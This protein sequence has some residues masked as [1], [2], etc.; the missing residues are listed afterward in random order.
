MKARIV[1]TVLCL[2]LAGAMMLGEVGTV[3]AAGTPETDVISEEAPEDAD[4]TDTTE[5]QP[6]E[7]TEGE[8]TEDGTDPIEADDAEGTEDQEETAKPEEAETPE[9]TTDPIEAEVPD[10]TADPI[11]AEVPDETADPIEAEVPDESGIPDETADP[12]E[13]LETAY[14]EEAAQPEETK[15][16]EE[17]NDAAPVLPAAATVSRNAAAEVQ[18]QKASSQ[19]ASVSYVSSNTYSYDRETYIYFNGYGS[20]FEIYVNGVKWRT[21]NNEKTEYDYETGEQVPASAPYYSGESFYFTNMIPG[22]TYKFKIVPYTHDGTA[23]TAKEFTGKINAP[24]I[25]SI[26]ASIS[27]TPE[28]NST[29]YGKPRVNLSAYISNG[30]SYSQTYEIWRAEGKKTATYKKIATTTAYNNVYYTDTTAAV[31]KN[32]F[33]KIRPIFKADGTYVKSD[34][35]GSYS[36]IQEVSIAKPT[37]SCDVSYDNGSAMISIYSYGFSSGFEIYRSNSKNKGYKKIAT[38]SDT[39]YTDNGLKDNKTYYY[40]VKPF[41]Y[42]YSAKKPKKYAGEYSKPAGVKVLMGS[43]YLEAT[44]SGSKKVSLTWAPVSGASS[45]E[46]YYKSN[47]AGD[48]YKRLAVTNKTSYTATSLSAEKYSFQVRAM[49]TAGDVKSYYQSATT[50]V[51]IGFKAPTNFRIT[52]KTVKVS[53]TTATIQST[54]KWDRVYGAKSYRIEATENGTVK[55]LKA[56]IKAGT[57]SYK[58]TNKVTNGTVKYSNIRIIAVDGKEEL[59]AYLS[60]S[61][62]TLNEVTNVKVKKNSASSAKI[63]WKKTACATSYSVYRN[64]P[65]GSSIFIGSTK[66]TSIVDKTLTPGV[67]YTYTVSAYNDKANISSGSS[68][69]YDEDTPP[70]NSA[71]YNHALGKTSISSIKNSKA[72]QAVITW[73]KAAYGQK[74]AVYRST[75]KNGTY[76]KIA[77]V[78]GKTSYTDTKLKK[79]TT[80]YYKVEVVTVNDA[81]LTVTSAKSAAK[82]IK[83]TK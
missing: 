23:G 26:S 55:V 43:I 44:Q 18:P 25:S 33:Y 30:G 10:E 5:E 27:S 77:T 50:S 78:N 1:K 47:L 41:Y 60:G 16:P 11:E 24:T 42:D 39:F 38:T 56:G 49:K 6:Q 52:K 70:T 66:N 22:V 57:T 62:S 65:T 79:G 13:A 76:K 29:G 83:I 64:T 82:S 59:S 74:Y 53:G 2:T 72:K 51:T 61:T 3:F 81:G 67:N 12:E 48:A 68:G 37:A 63:S 8:T 28:Q 32:Y 4:V 40:K 36:A 7:V 9:E 71:I 80:Y 75:K 45:Y 34:Q 54:L 73:K 46:I 20:K 14:T 15:E 58:L 35:A 21:V 69:Y 19:T 31:G 17:N